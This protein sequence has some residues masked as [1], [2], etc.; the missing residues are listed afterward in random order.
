[1]KLEKGIFAIA[2]RSLIQIA[3]RPI[4]WVGFFGIPLFM[5]LFITTMMDSG[6][7]HRIPAAM[8]DRDGTALSRQVTQSLSGMQNVNISQTLNS[9]TQARDALQKGEI[10][11]FFLIPENFQADL[12]GGRE[13]VITFYTNMTYFVPGSLLFKS[14]KTTATYTKAG[15]VMNI[16]DAA[17][18]DSS[19]IAPMLQPVNIQA[20]GIGNPTMN[21][22]IYLSNSFIPC[23]LQL[24]IMVVTCFSL[25]Q[26]IKYGTSRRLLRMADGSIVKALF[27]KLLPQTVIWWVIAAFMLV[28][29]YKFN[30]YT[31]Q[32]SWWIMALSEFFFVL[33]A[34]GFALFVFGVLPNMRLSMSICSLLGILSF[35]IAAFSFPVQSMYGAIAIFSYIVPIRYN[36]LIYADQ[37]LNGIDIYYS[38]VWFAA[39][40]VFIILP[41]TMLWKMKK[42]MEDPVYTP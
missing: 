21:Y 4:Y 42:Y 30:G 25:G 15:V 37:A 12:L 24:M 14:F 19:Q 18:G 23:L 9:Y 1:M 7:P 33:A 6:L 3:R 22:G 40:I 20:R 38:R 13:P 8:V 10:Y 36:F 16:A 11:G 27:A 17:G 35:S 26:E 41:F 39:Y 31:M 28:W 34:Q 2:V 32:C 29:L 5:F